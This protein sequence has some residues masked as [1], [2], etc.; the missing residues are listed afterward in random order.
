M[1]L[2]RQSIEKRDFP[3][4]RRGYDPAA[5][6]AHLR[7]I[8]AEVEELRYALE[9][10][11]GE[12]LGS[13]AGTQVQGILEAA[14]TTAADIEQKAAEDARQTRAEA[15]ADAERTRA[16]AVARAQAHVA[17]VAKA[18][19]V[20]S[21]R[22]ESMD[23]QSA[24]LV[25]SLRAGASRLAT[26]LTAVETNMAELY[27][28]AAGRAGDAATQSDLPPA[29]APMPGADTGADAPVRQGHSEFIPAPA[30]PAPASPAP[31]PPATA[32]SVASTP[33]VSASVTTVSTAQPVS[34]PTPSPSPTPARSE[35]SASA[36]NGDLDGARLIALNM[37][38]NGDSRAATDR[39]LAE[40]YELADRRKLLDEVF[41]AVEG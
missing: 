1:E 24:A 3:I 12:T 30:A 2:D 9:S 32:S 28:A 20:L 19:A 8:A 10:R 38:L 18:T 15:D 23:A 25:E 16:D 40:H 4:G 22:V 34:P 33:Q 14:E 6:D 41:A 7:T 26:D 11:A 5:V 17:A 13:S 39:Y 31:A 35:P 37:A 36:G 27:D 29:D 21:E